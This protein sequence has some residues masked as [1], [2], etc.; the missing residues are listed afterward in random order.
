MT[1][2]IIFVSIIALLFLFINL[3]FAPHNPK[4]WTGKSINWVKLS[5]SG[6]TL[7][8]LIL[9]INRKVNCGWSNYSGIVIS[10]KIYESIIGNRGSKSVIRGLRKLKPYVAVKEQ[11]VNGSWS[12]KSN[13]TDLRCT[14]VGLEISYQVKIPSNSINFKRNLSTLESKLN[15]SY[16]SGFVD[17]EGSFMLT[18]I[19]DNKYKLGWRVV[20]RFIISLHKKDLSLLNKIKEF[21]DVGNVFLMA[22]D[23][24]QYRVESLKG[25][26][27]IINHFDKYPLITKKQAD[28]KLFKMAHN[29]IKNKSHL[30]KEGLLELV[31]IKAVINNGLNNDL[32]IAFPGINAIL[33]PDTP[34][35]SILDPFWLSGFVD[36]EG[37]FSVVVFKSKTSK[38]G[39]AV[40]LS[41]ILTQSNRDEYLIKSLIE[42][43]GCGNTSLDPRGTIDFKVTNFSSIKDIIVPFFIKY[44]LKG[45]KSLDFTDFCEVVRLMEN[46]SHLTK[47]GLDQIKKIRSRM[48]TNRKQ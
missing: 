7:K 5:N 16:I 45:N 10:Q 30:T 48:N 24:A 39:E 41:F 3:V 32:S 1:L 44:P 47:E 18:I 35:P 19:K 27:L 33:R 43:L 29:L 46:K 6:K 23:S 11:R 25:L 13:L 8:L 2:F 37:C 26:D 14:L 34:L 36:G 22:K 21:F 20:C 9:S 42:Y 38:L 31:A 28:Y 17:G 4:I 15:P 40:K 12:V